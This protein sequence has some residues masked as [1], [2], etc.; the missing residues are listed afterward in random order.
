VITDLARVD[1]MKVSFAGARALC[2][3]AIR[4]AIVR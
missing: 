4:I 1:Q 3:H 2:G